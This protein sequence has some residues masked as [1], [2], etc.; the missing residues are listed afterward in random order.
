MLDGPGPDMQQMHMAALQ[1]DTSKKSA[2]CVAP[3]WWGQVD[4]KGG[5]CPQS[6]EGSM[7]GLLQ[8]LAHEVPGAYGGGIVNRIGGVDQPRSLLLCSWR[9]ENWRL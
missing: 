2:Q 5:R 6:G 1:I 3:P 4:V 8:E 7:S 9:L